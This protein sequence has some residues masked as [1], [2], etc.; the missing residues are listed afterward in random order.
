MVPKMGDDDAMYVQYPL[1]GD[2]TIGMCRTFTML[3]MLRGNAAERPTEKK[4]CTMTVA[5]IL[6]CV[7]TSQAIHITR[8]LR[9]PAMRMNNM[10]CIKP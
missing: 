9:Q 7:Y 10:G 3:T 5:K 1:V 2:S 6:S 4:S 8:S